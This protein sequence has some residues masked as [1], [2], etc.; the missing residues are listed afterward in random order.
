M[1]KGITEED[2]QIAKEPV[3]R[4]PVSLGQCQL[5]SQTSLHTHEND[6]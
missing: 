6:E 1:D 4:S 3:E 5:K 2:I